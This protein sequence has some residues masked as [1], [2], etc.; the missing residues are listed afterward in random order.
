MTAGVGI[1]WS[2]MRRRE[3]GNKEPQHTLMIECMQRVGGEAE[4]MWE[5]A[6]QES[7][8]GT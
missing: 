7:G 4:S 2:V 3:F 8:A 5:F 6:L 1:M